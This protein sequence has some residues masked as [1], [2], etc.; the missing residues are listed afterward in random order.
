MENEVSI[1]TWINGWREANG[2][3]AD[4]ALTEEQAKSF[5]AGFKENFSFT[6]DNGANVL[7]FGE[8]A[9]PDKIAE[10][11]GKYDEGTVSVISELDEVKLIESDDLR[12]AVAA[13]VGEEWFDRIYNGETVGEVTTGKSFED[14]L[15]V[16][17]FVYSEIVKNSSASEMIALVADDKVD[18]IWNRLLMSTSFA[19]DNIKTINGAEKPDFYNIIKT[20]MEYLGYSFEKSFGVVKQYIEFLATAYTNQNFVSPEADESY[21]DYFTR[22]FNNGAMESYSLMLE[23]VTEFNALKA[24]I[25]YFLSEYGDKLDE[26]SINELT[27]LFEKD[28][29]HLKNDIDAIHNVYPNG[30][31]YTSDYVLNCIESV[32]QAIEESTVQEE[33]FSPVANDEGNNGDVIGYNTTDNGTSEEAPDPNGGN[34]AEESLDGIIDTVPDNADS[35][36]ALSSDFGN[37]TTYHNASSSSHTI[38]IVGRNIYNVPWISGSNTP[39]PVVV[40][41]TGD[42][43]SGSYTSTPS[44]SNSDSYTV[45]DGVND[46]V[47]LNSQIIS[48]V[49]EYTKLAGGH[50][51]AFGKIMNG[52]GEFLTGAGA[53][54]AY[55]NAKQKPAKKNQ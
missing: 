45:V 3:S 2:L 7:V 22:V 54:A 51:E 17:D 41:E 47:N 16:R 44:T 28:Y 31:I 23:Y 19:N 39:K 48:A 40:T 24:D 13:A 27:C 1:I 8:N 25:L 33:I 49:S 12:N 55:F 52:A 35:T 43:V 15:A 6:S 42:N 36:T 18:N 32:K 21:N 37:T 53:V 30:Y 29:A 46:A 9:D 20:G 4:E 38:S 50:T 34:G 11:T 26:A 14:Q 5:L 10:L